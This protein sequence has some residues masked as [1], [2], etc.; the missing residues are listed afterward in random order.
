MIVGILG[1]GQLSRMLALAGKPLGIDF[2]FY[3][4]KDEHCVQHLGL[5][6]HGS[7][8]DKQALETF[9]NSV[10]VITFENENI[11]TDTL[12]YL[13][14]F[15]S[16]YPSKNA[17]QIMQDRLLE[18]EL[19]LSLNI[20]TTRFCPVDTKD[21]LIQALSDIPLPVVLKKRRLGYDGKGQ[22]VLREWSEVM[23]L[24]DEDCANS[25][26]E[27]FVPFDREVSIIA[28][29]NQG[30]TIAYYDLNE[31]VHREGILF[32][33]ESKLKDPSTDLAQHYIR[34]VLE[35]LDYVG[36]LTIEFFQRG[37]ALLVNE[38]APR[39]H[40]TGHWTIEGAVTS[41]F[42]NHLRCIL[43]W[44]LGATTRVAPTK[45]YNIIGHMPDKLSLLDI[46]GLCLHNYQKIAQPGRKLGHCNLLYPADASC[47]Q[48]ER[49]IDHLPSDR[50]Q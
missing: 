47:Y 38:F 11:P 10:D 1:G 32:S 23:E 3:E 29:R 30:G 22:R 37:N 33:T 31:N 48:I 13:E 9:A 42:E 15:K 17:L 28:C 27:A 50:F 35:H 12:A 19:C 7:Y 20:P 44:P 40:N 24:T 8:E 26:I 36:I 6:H 34:L 39:V 2:V 5:M 43:N 18:K 21:R 41:Q 45:M 46:P 16:V 25:I 4:P 14:S 49:L